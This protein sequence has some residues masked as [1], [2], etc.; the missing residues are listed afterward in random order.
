MGELAEVAGV[1]KRTI[2]YYTQM[3]LLTY[4]RTDANYRLYEANSIQVLHLIEHYK[5]LNMPLSKVK[6]TL[7]L[8]QKKECSQDINKVEEH[9]EQVMNMIQHLQ[10]EMNEIKPLIERLNDG[11]REAMMMKF[12]PQSVELAQSILAL[13]KEQLD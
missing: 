10:E 5:K 7:E 6:E 8:M 1:S 12:S 2:D 3:N 9:I 4:I 11:E 13:F